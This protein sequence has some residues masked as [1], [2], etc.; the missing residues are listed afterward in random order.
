MGGICGCADSAAHAAAGRV[1]H[2]FDSL[3]QPEVKQLLLDMATKYQDKKRGHQSS[4]LLTEEQ[5]QCI[6]EAVR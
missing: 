4:D 3:P 2:A 6:W 5:V 1:L